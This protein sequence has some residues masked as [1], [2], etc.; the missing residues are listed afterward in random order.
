[1]RSPGQ[2][3]PTTSA[4]LK[5]TKRAS[6]RPEPTTSA[7]PLVSRTPRRSVGHVG[8]AREAGG[9][10]LYFVSDAPWKAQRRIRRNLPLDRIPWPFWGLHTG[11]HQEGSRRRPTAY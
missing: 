2:E 9:A 5:S 10:A 4:A 6:Q 8:A 1:M 11:G 7:S 3:E